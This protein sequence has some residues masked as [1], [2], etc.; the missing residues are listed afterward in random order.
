MLYNQEISLGNE[1]PI[2]LRGGMDAWALAPPDLAVG[3][4]GMNRLL[5][6]S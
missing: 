5:V 1:I 4:C 2:D 3:G 6:S